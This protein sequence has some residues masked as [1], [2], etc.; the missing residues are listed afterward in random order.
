M[1]VD[2]LPN[3]D[4]AYGE[5]RAGDEERP[6]DPDRLGDHTAHHRT[7]RNANVDAG[8][9]LAHARG[10]ALAGDDAGHQ[11]GSGRDRSG[12]HPLQDA[13]DEELA[14]VLHQPHE[15]DDQPANQQRAQDHDLSAVAVGKRA[16]DWAENGQRDAGA[17][18]QRPRPEDHRALRGDPDLFE[19]E[20]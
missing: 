9:Q 17:R 5:H 1:L 16:P 13:Q 19:V 2:E 7:G 12:E 4:A 14:D 3:E 10:E 15:G 6:T 11:R 18:H 8:L 20:R